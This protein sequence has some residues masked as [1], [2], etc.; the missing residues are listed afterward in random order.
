MTPNAAT[1]MKKPDLTECFAVGCY[2]LKP[3]WALMCRAHWNRVPAK[4]QSDIYFTLRGFKA[5]EDPTP[6]L[7]ATH[8]A[9]LAVAR[10]DNLG[11]DIQQAITDEIVRFEAR[12]DR[13]A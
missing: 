2:A 8:Q 9:Q 5:N 13:E 3:R 11:D 12:M 6:Y 1:S 10:F 4:I 7:I